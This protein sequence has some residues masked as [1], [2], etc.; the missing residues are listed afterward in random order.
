MQALQIFEVV[1]KIGKH[2]SL[3]AGLVVGGKDVQFEQERIGRMNILVA[4]PGRLL[5][6]MDQAHQFEC[7]HLEMLGKRRRVEIE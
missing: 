1:R 2:H 5:H 6:H 3:S 4:T 7:S